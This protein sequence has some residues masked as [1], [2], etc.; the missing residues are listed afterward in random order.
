M[1]RPPNAR[2]R[3]FQT[4][5]IL[6]LAAAI[7]ALPGALAARR[8]ASPLLGPARWVGEAVRRAND[9]V[10]DAKAYLALPS[11]AKRAAAAAH[12]VVSAIAE[13]RTNELDEVGAERIRDK[14]LPFTEV[15][16]LAALRGS[17]RS[18]GGLGRDFYQQYH[19]DTPPELA[20]ATALFRD[21]LTALRTMH[22]ACAMVEGGTLSADEEEAALRK[23]GQG[24][25]VRDVAT[26]ATRTAR[27]AFAGPGALRRMARVAAYE[28]SL[29][30]TFRQLVQ[31]L[32]RAGRQSGALREAAR[33]VLG[34]DAGDLSWLDDIP[35]AALDEAQAVVLAAQ[36]VRWR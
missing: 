26:R 28:L 36:Q 12:A 4:V 8:D 33:G 19:P 3:A 31:A 23:A 9:A 22:K 15:S 1:R 24:A 20:E 17:P 5:S 25:D 32:A 2:A 30:K 7:T 21:L 13:I 35:H 18:L 6:L 34:E 14:L 11:H 27:R 29:D 10:H 16:L